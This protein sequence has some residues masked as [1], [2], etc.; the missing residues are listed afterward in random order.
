MRIGIST[1]VIQRGRT[2]IA[3]Y[4]FA[5]LRAFGRS[6]SSHQFFLFVL[7]EDLPLLEFARD[8]AE[9]I[10][11]SERHRPAVS[12]I[13]WHQVALP[14]LARSLRLDVLHVPSYRRMLWAQPC[15]TV[16]TIHDLAPFHVRRK[17]D[18]PRMMYGRVACRWLARRQHQIIAIS[19]NTAHDIQQFF[20]IPSRQLTVIYNGLDH[21]RFHPTADP[22]AGGLLRREFQ[23]EAP[24]F[25]YVARL[26]HPGKNHVRLL[27]AFEIFKKRTG[28]EWLL[29]LAGSDWHGAAHIHTAIQFSPVREAVRVL[30][31]VSDERL[32]DLYRE[33]RAFVYP[34][35]YEGFGMPPVEAMACG[36]PVICSSRGSLGEVVGSAALIV[37]PES[38]ESIAAALE[39][40]AAQAALR[41]RL[42]ELGRP[43]A[44]RFDWRTT[45][46][47]TLEVYRAAAEKYWPAWHFAPSYS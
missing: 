20:R 30:G 16:A 42:S 14:R 2:G 29:A 45:G 23:L 8:F 27:S 44:A 17:Y 13:L 39:R 15:A 31:F 5:L 22:V 7:E 46:A 11:V 32:P 43:H 41:S 6:G 19:H 18:L 26:E 37:D 4:L 9:L 36:C 47:R 38:P 25:L 35:L 34:S 33:A 1:S 24:F 40:L 21:D 10:I 3:Q 12:N 28:S